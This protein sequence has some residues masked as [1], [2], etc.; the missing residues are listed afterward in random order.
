MTNE[1]YKSRL[2]NSEEKKI[3]VVDA[4]NRQ[5]GGEVKDVKISSRVLVRVRVGEPYESVVPHDT[6]YPVPIY[7]EDDGRAHAIYVGPE[8]ETIDCDIEEMEVIE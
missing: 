2:E 3:A 4:K 1:K 8:S 5:W 6:Y 7:V